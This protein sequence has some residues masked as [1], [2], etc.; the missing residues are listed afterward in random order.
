MSTAI[1]VEEPGTLAARAE[2]KQQKDKNIE[3]IKKDSEVVITTPKSK[4]RY[5]RDK[6]FS[7]FIS[8]ALTYST[9]RSV[10]IQSIKVGI[11]Y[12]LS[13]ILILAYIIG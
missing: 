10:T 12:R 13:Q 1:Y 4:I 11:A 8:Y 6:F 9:E 3:I 2:L 5:K 7:L